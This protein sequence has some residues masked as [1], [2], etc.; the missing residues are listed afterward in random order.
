M[1]TMLLLMFM[2]MAAATVS[3]QPDSRTT[4]Y[5]GPIRIPLPC[6]DVDLSVRHVTE[7]A[8]MGGVNTVE[9]A[10]KNK[11][12]SSCTLIG[13]PRFELLDKAGK[14]RPHGRAI[15][16]RQMP[17]EESKHTP[18]V[19][20]IL[21]GSEAGFAVYYNSGGAGYMGKPCPVTRRVGITAPGT[22]RRFIL[23]DQINSCSDL[24]VFAI[25][26]EVRE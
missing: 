19:V 23:R 26:A 22:T 12:S 16:S 14:V 18:Q 3:A 9:Y 1:R 15:N 8:A 24:Q 13:Y 11:S 25:R 4:T 2:A 10:F 7:D 5:K 21:P 6:R 20:L 17:G